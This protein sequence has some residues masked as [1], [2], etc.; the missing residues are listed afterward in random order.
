MDELRWRATSFIQ[1]KE[2]YEF[3][4]KGWGDQKKPNSHKEIITTIITLITT[5]KL[6][7][8]SW[9]QHLIHLRSRLFYDFKVNPCAMT[10]KLCETCKKVDEAHD[11]VVEHE[12]ANE[13]RE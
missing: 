10:S 13:A 5:L 11:N 1:M 9:F 12:Y 3:H 7:P 8:Y 2:L 4:D 6:C